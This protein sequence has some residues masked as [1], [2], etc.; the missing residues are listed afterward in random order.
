MSD[1]SSFKEQKNLTDAWR[2][3]LTEKYTDRSI[4]GFVGAASGGLKDK[5]PEEKAEIATTVHNIEMLPPGQKCEPAKLTAEILDPGVLGSLNTSGQDWVADGFACT[6]I[7]PLVPYAAQIMAKTGEG[8]SSLMLLSAATAFSRDAADD[9]FSFQG[10]NIVPQAPRP[11]NTR[12]SHPVNEVQTATAPAGADAENWEVLDDLFTDKT[13]D[14]PAVQNQLKTYLEGTLEKLFNTIGEDVFKFIWAWAIIIYWQTLLE[15][16]F[17]DL[18]SKGGPAGAGQTLFK[19]ATMIAEIEIAWLQR[20]IKSLQPEIDKQRQINREELKRVAAEKFPQLTQRNY[21][22][23]LE[24]DIGPQQLIR[25]QYKQYKGQSVNLEEDWQDFINVLGRA[26]FEGSRR[27]QNIQEMTASQIGLIM[28][29]DPDMVQQIRTALGA[30]AKDSG[31]RRI[32]DAFKHVTPPLRKNKLGK[33][34]VSPDSKIVRYLR[35]VWD[36]VDRRE[37]QPTN[38]ALLRESTIKRW[39]HLAGIKKEVI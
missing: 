15:Q 22:Y 3:F 11:A 6:M 13:Y 2:S 17:M 34:V 24:P 12:F 20:L 28:G 38:E 35:Q 36:A 7:V 37:V 33:R 18:K 21:E 1:W 5:T 16:D 9:F 27:P 26:K 4:Q 32:L 30:A 10:M 39:K 31:A 29:G 14:L 25:D 19:N 8:Q 23:Y